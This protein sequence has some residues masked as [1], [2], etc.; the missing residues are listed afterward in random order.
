MNEMSDQG[1]IRTV[2]RRAII[3]CVVDTI[4]TM[5]EM[6]PDI[7][8]D[9]WDNVVDEVALILR[10]NIKTPDEE[11]DEAYALLGKRASR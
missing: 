6:Y 11:F 5:W 8:E 7:G 2:A 4:D 1:A 9:D 10:A 3:D